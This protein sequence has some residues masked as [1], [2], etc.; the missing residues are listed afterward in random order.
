ML[1]SISE[2]EAHR[3][4]FDDVVVIKG[5]QSEEPEAWCRYK[6]YE[7]NDIEMMMQR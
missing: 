1:D 7:D 6:F 2:A 5:G 4:G 3:A